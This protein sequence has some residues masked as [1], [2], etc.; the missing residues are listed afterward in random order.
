ML[1]KPA[2]LLCAAA[3]APSFANAA[4]SLQDL[5]DGACL[6][7]PRATACAW[8]LE[9][10][11]STVTVDYSLIDMVFEIQDTPLG[12]IPTIGYEFN[13]QL[14]VQDGDEVD[15]VFSYILNADKAIMAD[16]LELTDIVF[17]G[18]GGFI[19][20]TEAKYS[21]GI[22]VADLVA[23]IDPDFGIDNNPVTVSL[24]APYYQLLVQKSVIIQSFVGGTVSVGDMH[25]G[26]AVPAP[27]SLALLA[28]GLAGIAAVRRRR[29]RT[30]APD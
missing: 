16:S 1:N 21:D 19:E 18:T 9:K 6:S 29:V 5:F 17:A 22:L 4:L 10:D 30:G 3:L 12:A 15:F 25:Q 13:S 26:H 23:E 24:G 14:S 27:A 8:D 7:G 2:L 20:V 11:F 28:S